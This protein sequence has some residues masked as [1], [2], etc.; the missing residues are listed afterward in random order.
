MFENAGWSPF[1]GTGYVRGQTEEGSVA[2]GSAA[3][4]S[5]GGDGKHDVSSSNNQL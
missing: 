3:A 5:S 1:L 4:K 2:F